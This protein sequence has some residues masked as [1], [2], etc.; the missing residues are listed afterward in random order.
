MPESEPS[1][2]SC[3]SLPV[4]PIR[5][6]SAAQ[7]APVA[8][9]DQLVAA[10]QAKFEPVCVREK[11][12][13]TATSVVAHLEHRVDAV[14]RQV[15]DI[16]RLEPRAGRERIRGDVR[17]VPAGVVVEHDDLR[18][19]AGKEAFARSC[20]LLFV[21]RLSGLPVLRTRR[22]DFPRL[23]QLRDALHVRAEHDE[24]GAS[25]ASQVF[26]AKLWRRAASRSSQAAPTETIHS[27]ASSSG[28]GV[29]S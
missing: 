5:R 18:C 26:F 2:C 6:V 11:P 8:L 23:A 19:P 14:L 15:P 4:M 24:H 21:T 27:T 16:P 25:I 29:T 12:V 3:R 22:E 1:V 9:R 17:R 28:A 13:H 20:D 10:T 7:A